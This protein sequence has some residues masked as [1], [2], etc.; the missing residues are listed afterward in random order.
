MKQRLIHGFIL[1][2][3][4]IFVHCGGT[5]SKTSNIDEM[6]LR[7]MDSWVDPKPFDNCITGLILCMDAI[8]LIAPDTSFPQEFER[9]ILLTRKLFD[10]TSVLNED[11]YTMLLASYKM[12][13]NGVNFQ[14]PEEIDQFRGALEYNIE[15]AQVA[16]EYLEE[17]EFENCI[18]TLLNIVI[19]HVTPVRE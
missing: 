19:L 6:I 9:T 12:I 7:A 16:R 17:K 14:L 1:M 15:Q 3:L 5:H 18:R 2:F 4:I 10:S 13:N 8:A 11:A